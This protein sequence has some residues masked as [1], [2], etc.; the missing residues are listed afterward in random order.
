MLTRNDIK[1]AKEDALNWI[2]KKKISIRRRTKEIMRGYS[3]TLDF[4]HVKKVLNK[5]DFLN[6]V[7]FTHWAQTDGTSIVLNGNEDW[8]YEKLVYTLIHEA[9]HFMIKRN[10]IHYITEKK[11]HQIM[12][13]LDPLIIE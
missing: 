2:L 6:T 9:L 1:M 7:N 3:F 5:I 12:Y 4:L 11:E 10:G 8:E 13:K